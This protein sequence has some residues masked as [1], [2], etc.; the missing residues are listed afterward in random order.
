MR[1]TRALQT[2]SKRLSS[3][4]CPTPGHRP[5]Q[6]TACADGTMALIVQKYGGTSVGNTDR[7]KNV[8]KR[9]AEYRRARRQGCRRRL[10]DERRDRR[11]H[12]TGQGH[13]AA[14]ERT[15]D[16]HAAGHRRTADHRA[17]G[18]RAAHAR[19]SGRFHD[20]RAGGH[21]HRWR[22]H[23]GENPQHHAEESSRASQRRATSSSSPV[24]KAKRAKARSPRSAAAV[25][26]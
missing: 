6:Q 22:S 8:A 15:R 5:Q 7:I 2:V 13:R 21:R 19:R 17:H 16:G 10:R 26:I 11:P 18:H 1:V 9:V 14:A 24:F 25:R 23:Q 4:A 3:T 20:R 12:Q